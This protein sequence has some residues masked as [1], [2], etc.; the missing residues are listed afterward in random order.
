MKKHTDPSKD[1]FLDREAE[2]YETPVP[3]REFILMALKSFK[4]PVKAKQL[5]H[6]YQLT[7]PDL[8]EAFNRRLKAMIRDGQVVK[9]RA[10]FVIVE[11]QSVVQGKLV[12]FKEGDGVCVTEDNQSIPIQEHG[13]R[14]FYDGDKISVQVRKLA[15]SNEVIGRI[16]QLLEATEPTV[17]GRFYKHHKL[18]KVQSLDRKVSAH[19][20]IPKSHNGKA[21]PGDIVLVRILREERFH[22]HYEPVGE[23]IEIL[24]D[25]A[26]TGIEIQMAIKKFNLPT[27]FPKPVLKACEKLPAQ[28]TPQSKRNREDLTKLCFVT[29][30][31]EDAKDFDDAVYCESHA[32]GWRLWVAIAD[33]SHYVK[34]NTPLDKEAKLRGNSTYF[35]EA[36]IPMLPEALSNDLCSLRPLEDRLTVVCQMSVNLEGKVTRSVFKRAVIN[37]KARLTYTKVAAIYAGDSTLTKE[38]ERQLPSLKALLEVYEALNKQR[39]LRGALDLDTIESKIVFDDKGKIEKIVPVVRNVAHKVIEECMLATNVCAAKLILR[40]KKPGLYRVHDTPPSEKLK[41]LRSFIHEL[42]LSLNGKDKPKPADIAQLLTDV[43][44]RADRHLIETVILRSL[45]QAQYRP[46]NVGHFGLAYPHYVHFTSPIRR[47]PDLIIHRI[48]LD[49]LEANAKTTYDF[50]ALDKMATHLSQTERRSDEATRDAV[51]ALKCHYMQDKI[52]EV[53]EGV[54]TGVTHFGIFV[55]LK[56]IFIEGLV[57]V[58]QLGREYFQYDP[59]KHRMLGDVTRQSYQLGQAVRVKVVRVDLEDK[60]IDF[61]LSD[62][63]ISNRKENAKNKKKNNK[64]T[65]QK[66]EIFSEKKG[67]KAAPKDKK[68]KKLKGKRK[69]VKKKV[70]RDK[71]FND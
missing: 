47:F 57:H 63:R 4:H 62:A 49:I 50:E 9:L 7:D 59:I 67:K 38:Y 33:V 26:T 68:A 12:L 53:Y 34:P 40:H 11:A 46:Q 13:L 24:G 8:I 6:H 71:I 51:Y 15:D 23:V 39:K 5:I 58:S 52:G 65:Q 41:Q 14:G 66:N 25:F 17:V 69:K 29:I 56:E 18:F 42:G 44:E 30:D 70:K 43:K 31:G 19:I 45:S 60:K 2:K 32:N 64:S 1:P 22:T 61:E 21:K 28:V 48:V 37:S 10:G 35:P 27:V 55:E 20:T 36:V 54:I 3:S 16:N